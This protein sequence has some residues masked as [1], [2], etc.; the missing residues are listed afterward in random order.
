[1]ML[2]TRQR[3]PLVAQAFRPVTRPPAALKGC[4]TG[5]SETL[6]KRLRDVLIMVIGLAMLSTVAQPTAQAPR[7]LALVAGMLLTGDEVPP[8][9][10]V[11]VVIEGNKIVAAGPASEIRIPADATVVDTSG[12]VILP[13]VIETHGHLVVVGH[14][15]YDTWFPWIKNHGGDAMLTRVIEIG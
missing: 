8:V 9:H 1:M 2:Q 14:G 3:R 4:A 10:H 7:R 11:A 6:S 15:S 13:G 12:R 5:N